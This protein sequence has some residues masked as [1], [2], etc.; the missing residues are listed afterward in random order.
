M[1]LVPTTPQITP[2][3]NRPPVPI[4]VQPITVELPPSPV[5]SSFLAETSIIQPIPRVQRSLSLQNPRVQNSGVSGQNSV[6][7]NA[8]VPVQNSNPRIHNSEIQ[9]SGVE[10][11]TPISSI[12]VTSICNPIPRI[13]PISRV[14]NVL[15]QQPTPI[16]QLNSMIQP[17]NLN[18][19]LQASA[20]Q[21]N[22]VVQPVTDS[23]VLFST[24]GQ[25][26]TT[27]LYITQAE[28]GRAHV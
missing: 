16:V 17:T 15:V 14:Q 19:S 4:P 18:P 25:S 26:S 11:I 20:I 5:Q 24:V 23:S 8:R 13:P 22:S 9:I 12:H 2:I 10:N 6:V 21:L 28:I 27:S 1:E 7:S 3:A